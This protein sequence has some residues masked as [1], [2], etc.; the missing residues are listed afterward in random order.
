[1]YF[2]NENKTWYKTFKNEYKYHLRQFNNPKES[3]LRFYTFIKKNL[4]SSKKVVDIAAGA[5]AATCFFASKATNTQ[6]TALDINYKLLKIGK[7]FAK[8]KKISNIVFKKQDLYKLKSNFEYDGGGVILLQTLSWLSEIKKP[9]RCIFRLQ[10][11]WLALS[12][13]F[14]EGDITC[15]IQ[16]HEHKL[17]RKRFYNIYS[18]P[19]LERIA[20]SNNYFIKKISNFNI[21]FDIKKSKDPDFMGTYTRTLINSNNT[22]SRIQI[23]GPLLLPWKFILLEK[24]IK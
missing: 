15:K 8:K 21:N 13:L 19:E 7:K 3:T 12:S 20:D 11:N 17:N 14:Y 22:K 4:L 6:F 10:P 16:I 18:I 24:K 9:L 1:M 5:A 23:S 2:E